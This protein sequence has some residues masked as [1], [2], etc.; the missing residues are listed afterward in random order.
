MFLSKKK[1]F[2]TQFWADD[3]ILPGIW[4]K[5]RIPGW[6]L[7]R[8]LGGSFGQRL[9]WR[10]S[11]WNI[12]EWIINLRWFLAVTDQWLA[13]RTNLVHW[14]AMVENQLSLS[15]WESSLSLFSGRSTHY[16]K[17]KHFK[18]CE[19]CADFK[20]CEN[21]FGRGLLECLYQKLTRSICERHKINNVELLA[22]PIWA[23]GETERNCSQ[24]GVMLLANGHWKSGIYVLRK[25]DQLL[26]WP[27][28]NSLCEKVRRIAEIFVFASG[29]HLC[30]IWYENHHSFVIWDLFDDVVMVTFICMLF[31]RCHKSSA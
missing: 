8:S 3:I 6:I 9:L 1:F 22:S 11:N 20:S 2:K 23:V 26:N 24:S 5:T 29:F 10:A 28:S 31:A 7:R 21:S 14:N 13:G 4:A 17:S 18:C 25:R 16:F 30:W 15:T 12:D 27:S 19:N